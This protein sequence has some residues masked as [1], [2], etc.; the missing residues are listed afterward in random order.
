MRDI[1]D[2]ANRWTGQ[3]SGALSST[4]K[5]PVAID[6]SLSLLL[7]N[8]PVTVA[9]LSNDFDP[10]GQ[11][12]TLISASAGLGTAIANAD[13]TVTYMVPPGITGNDTVVYEIAD[14]LD[15]RQTGQINVTINAPN[16]A[17]NTLSDNTMIVTA[18]AAAIDLSVTQPST[19]AGTTSFHINDL[20]G[21]PV[22]LS[23]PKISG[24]PQLGATVT[25]NTGLWVYDT[26][27]GEP[28]QSWQWR[29]AGVDIAGATG[30]SYTLGAADVGEELA[31]LETQTDGFGQRSSLS[32]PIGGSNAAF[33]PWA[34]PTLVAWYDASD[35]ATITSTATLLWEDK[36]G[37]ADL[38]Q[39]LSHRLPTTGNRVQNGLNVLDFNGNASMET[40]VT[41]PASGDVA[42]HMAVVID[43]A[44]NPYAAVL[45]LDA[46]NDMQIDANDETAFNG[47]L[48]V[49]GI[50]D[51]VDLTGG[52]FSGALILSAVFDRTGAGTATVFISDVL[53]GSATY[54]TPLDAATAL[55]V[56][57]NR[58]RN[59]EVT[60][61]VCELVITG[62]V[63]NRTDYHTYLAQKWG[64]A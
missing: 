61:A 13:N 39:S 4:N 49:T 36:A 10:E 12:L 33:A 9:V 11:T 34:D 6:D 59:S 3:F 58:S 24:L 50:G 27:A 56:M 64:I 48:N 17:V 28:V 15:Q 60:G 63:S 54:S 45:A 25:A 18:A 16:L 62:D 42:L 53:R 35:T 38:V 26:D 37:T 8:G 7:D 21:G 19:F 55:H 30:S 5:E 52:P 22:S 40:P 23:A 31:V 29:R 2:L 46:T 51:V 47:R 1:L 32:S 44:E 41:L 57:T 43:S 20:L 14:D